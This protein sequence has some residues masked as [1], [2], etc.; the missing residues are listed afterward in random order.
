V[1]VSA[2][3]RRWSL[4]GGLVHKARFGICRI[5]LRTPELSDEGFDERFQAMQAVAAVPA[6]GLVSPRALVAD[7]GFGFSRYKDRTGT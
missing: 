4:E 1:F 5:S 7:R 6:F 2:V 3:R